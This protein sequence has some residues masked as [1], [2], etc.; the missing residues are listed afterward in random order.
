M[1][2]SFKYLAN[3]RWNTN[4][5]VIFNKRFIF[6]FKNRW[7][8]WF[9]TKSLLI[10]IS[11]FQIFAK[12]GLQI[13]DTSLRWRVRMFLEVPFFAQFVKKWTLN[14][15]KNGT[16]KNIPTRHLKDVSDICSLILAN[17][18]NE[19]ILLNKNEERS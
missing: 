4:W 16:F 17:I 8:I 10:R 3:C 2:R 13:S 9:S 6:L 1:H 15:I 5:S 18:S 12:I 14:N 19:E 11:S 7:H